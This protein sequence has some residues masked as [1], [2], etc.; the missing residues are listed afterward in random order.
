MLTLSP[1]SP[2]LLLPL[3]CTCLFQYTSYTAFFLASAVSLWDVHTVF[4]GYY[5]SVTSLAISDFLSH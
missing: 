3:L 4:V 1:P 2:S 5:L